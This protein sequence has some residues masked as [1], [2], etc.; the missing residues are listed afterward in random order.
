MRI[1][2]V[3]DDDMIGES[4]VAGL[5]CEGH[6]VDWVRDGNSALLALNTTEF[7]L[8][9]LDLGLPGKDGL[10]GNARQAQRDACSR[11]NRPGHG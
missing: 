7:S 1:L 6:A 5:E 2:L 9:I 3:E 10:Q 8:V 11:H 4:V